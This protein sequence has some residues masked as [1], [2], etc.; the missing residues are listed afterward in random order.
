MHSGMSVSMMKQ[1]VPRKREAAFLRTSTTTKHNMY[2][3][4]EVMSV[5]VPNKVSQHCHLVYTF[6]TWPSEKK[7]IIIEK[8]EKAQRLQIAFSLMQLYAW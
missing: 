5:S 1:K 4:V 8:K 7:K 2:R 3:V 6:G